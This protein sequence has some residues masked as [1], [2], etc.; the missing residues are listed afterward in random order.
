MK[1]LSGD[2][3]L[4]CYI[5]ALA[6]IRNASDPDPLVVVGRWRGKIIRAPRGDSGLVMT[7]YFFPTT[8]T[9]PGRDRPTG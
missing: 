9:K 5:C 4:G 8:S 1:Y 7:Q 6:F 3:R 2:N